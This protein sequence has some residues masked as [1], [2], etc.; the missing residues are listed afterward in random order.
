[1][2]SADDLNVKRKTDV[3]EPAMQLY[4]KGQMRVADIAKRYHVSSAT[5]S[6]HAKKLGLPR[7]RR[8]RWRSGRPSAKQQAI[9]AQLKES[10]GAEVGRRNKISRQRVHQIAKRW[11]NDKA[12]LR[13]GEV[14]KVSSKVVATIEGRRIHVISF[15]LTSDEV[16]AFLTTRKGTNASRS[17]SPNQVA[18]AVVTKFLDDKAR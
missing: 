9:L 18:R 7:K 10:S 14:T 12:N 6:I 5:I 16:S 11:N 3:L 4:A 1:M 8:G 2:L 13:P 17:A 15:R